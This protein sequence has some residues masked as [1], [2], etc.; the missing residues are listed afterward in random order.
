MPAQNVE[1]KFSIGQKVTVKETGRDAWVTALFL[2]RGTIN[3]F[4]IKTT[5]PSGEPLLEWKQE[6]QLD[7]IVA[8]I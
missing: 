2:D 8:A 5:L 4:Y 7:D 6:M 1:F 3:Q